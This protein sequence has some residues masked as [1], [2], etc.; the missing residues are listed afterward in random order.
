M[1]APKSLREWYRLFHNLAKSK[2]KPNGSNRSW[3]IINQTIDSLL[4]VSIVYT[5]V[6]IQ[7][8][9]MFGTLLDI[10]WR[11]T[12]VIWCYPNFLYDNMNIAQLTI[13]S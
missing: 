6:V 11:H 10:S 9:A 7:E 3:N 1:K 8:N 5:Y 13:G 12:Y 2:A 4:G